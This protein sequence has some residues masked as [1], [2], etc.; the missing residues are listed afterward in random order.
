MPED[1]ESGEWGCVDDRPF[2]CPNDHGIM[3]TESSTSVHCPECG[4]SRTVIDHVETDEKEPRFYV[5]GEQVM[6]R[7]FKFRQDE[8]R[9]GQEY[10][11]LTAIIQFHET[12]ETA[13]VEL[14][15]LKA[16][17][18]AKAIWDYGVENNMIPQW[19]ADNKEPSWERE[20][21]DPTTDPIF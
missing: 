18:G 13:E 7:G 1:T 17:G 19:M 8:T 15:Q 4:Y 6:V 3:E 5:M 10:D 12:T 9:G 14:N 21:H 2:E 20:N 16:E 11:H